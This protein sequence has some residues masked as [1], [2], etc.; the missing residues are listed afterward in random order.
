MSDLDQAIREHLALKRQHG[1]DPSEVARQESEVFGVRAREIAADFATAYAPQE[2]AD[3]GVAPLEP[4]AE[5]R[6]RQELVAPA[7]EYA[8]SGLRPYMEV[9]EE[10]QEY[11]IE[12]RVGWSIGP[13]W[14]GGAA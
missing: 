1:A 6:L 10:T 7:D 5:P 8:R 11:T 12:D 3:F 13:A 14:Q 9:G 2:H 4:A